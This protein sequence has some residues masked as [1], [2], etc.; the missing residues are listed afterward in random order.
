MARRL[1]M[2]RHPPTAHLL[3]TGR[4][5]A[6]ARL[7]ATAGTALRAITCPQWDTLAGPCRPP[8]HRQKGRLPAEGIRPAAFCRARALPAR[9][10][11]RATMPRR[12]RNRRPSR[13]PRSRAASPTRARPALRRGLFC[14]SMGIRWPRVRYTVPDVVLHERRYSRQIGG[15]GQ[16]STARSRWLRSDR[17]ECGSR[18]PPSTYVVR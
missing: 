7:P 18:Y 9:H 13:P 10:P 6:M 1:A 2:G 15:T 11:V 17:R 5:L 8:H 3:A 16:F 12:S 14:A 4:R